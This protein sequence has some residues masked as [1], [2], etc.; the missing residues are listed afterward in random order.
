[1][2]ILV[3][4]QI[5]AALVL[6][7]VLNYLGRLTRGFGYLNFSEIFNRSQIGYNLV[8][9]ILSPAIFISILSILLYVLGLEYFVKNIWLTTVWYV[10]I[11]LLILLVLN[12]FSLTEKLTYILIQGAAI[13]SSYAFYILALERGLTYIL[14]DSGNFRT[15]LWFIIILYLYHLSNNYQPNFSK[16]ERQKQKLIVKRLIE[17]HK[18]Y[19]SKL[20]DEFRTNIFLKKLLFS[21]MMIEDINRPPFLRFLERIFSRVRPTISTGIMQVRSMKGL[22][23]DESVMIAQQRLLDSYRKNSHGHEYERIKVITEEYNPGEEYFTAIYEIY[24]RYASRVV[25]QDNIENVNIKPQNTSPESGNIEVRDFNDQKD[26]I[27]KQVFELFTQLEP[28][29]SEEE[30]NKIIESLRKKYE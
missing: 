12:R 18:K 30:K 25:K 21:I 4:F 17:L 9:R 5:C 6:V 1:M 3:L 16:I 7:L 20:I 29:L 23:D 15:E 26:E 14:P 2:I 22:S 8:L 13:L 27:L 24:N 10:A 19:E 11:H 28:L